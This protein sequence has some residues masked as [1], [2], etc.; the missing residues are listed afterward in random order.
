MTKNE[1]RNL[2]RAVVSIPIGS[3]LLV[4]DA[5]SHDST[6]Q[7]A[8]AHGATVVVRPWAGF[9]TT[10]AFAL[11]QIATP[12]T[13]MLD[14]DESLDLELAAALRALVPQATTD[15]YGVARATSF[16]GR[17]MHHGAWGGEA[18]VRLFRTACARVVAEPAAGGDA[19]L[20]ERWIVPGTTERI[21][22]TLLHDSYPTIA[23]YREKFARYTALEARGVTP[24]RGRFARACAIAA[25]RFPWLLVA[26]GGWRDGWRGAF[27]ACA[28]ACYPVAV[29]WKALRS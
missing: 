16:C 3:P 21:G 20:H 18:P 29:A 19:E 24:S 9:V 10:R 12:W 6:V 15:A 25:L 7:I 11:T 5:E 28:S 2:P 17:A 22:G 14:A 26:R 23:A 8:R 13:F 4:I 1:A 27:V